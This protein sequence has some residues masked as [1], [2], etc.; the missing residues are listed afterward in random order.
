MHPT[1]VPTKKSVGIPSAAEDITHLGSLRPCS[2]LGLSFA[3]L[4]LAAAES[5]MG[6]LSKTSASQTPPQGDG[7][8]DTVGSGRALGIL[9]FDKCPREFSSSS[10]PRETLYYYTFKLERSWWLL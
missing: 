9:I 2:F 3:C 8:A 4:C 10:K 7:G 5:C 1:R 6:H